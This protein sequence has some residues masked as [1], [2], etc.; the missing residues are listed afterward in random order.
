[1]RLFKPSKV[2]ITLLQ[3]L[4]IPLL[5]YSFTSNSYHLNDSAYG[6]TSSLQKEDHLDFSGDGSGGNQSD[7][8]SRDGQC[9]NVG[10]IWLTA[11]IPVSGNG[12]TT[13]ARPTLWFYIPY[14]SSQ[15]ALAEF[16]INDNRIPLI[17]PETPGYTSLRIPQEF[18][19]EVDTEYKW[20]LEIHCDLRNRKKIPAYVNGKIQ[21][22]ESTN[23]LS[24]QLEEPGIAQELV[25]AE[26]GLWFDAI[27]Y[28]SALRSQNPSDQAL[29]LRWQ[30]LLAVKGVHLDSMPQ[31]PFVGT[32]LE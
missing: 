24:T 15:I 1:M 28:V 26:Y 2:T 21:R 19:L 12:K 8:A 18:S 11:L 6:V 17:V 32:L 5:V 31:E 9:P 16:V 4:I 23:V 27:N 7:G 29:L 30:N 22:I 20:F 3:V 10:N 13:E 25:Y 14:T